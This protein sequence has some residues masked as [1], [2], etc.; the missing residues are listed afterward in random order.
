MKIT[1]EQVRIIIKEELKKVL[2]EVLYPALSDPQRV[3]KLIRAAEKAQENYTKEWERG[4]NKVFSSIRKGDPEKKEANQIIF[5]KVINDVFS[6][7]T[8]KHQKDNELIEALYEILEQDPEVTVSQALTSVKAAGE[9][10]APEGSQ[11]HKD[12]MADTNAVQRSENV[13]ERFLKIYNKWYKEYFKEDSGLSINT[14][15]KLE[16]N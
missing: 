12:I 9:E 6:N 14:P 8:P 10:F 11:L 1:R 16:Y 13:L 2:K 7:T 5:D 4:N 15:R 3:E